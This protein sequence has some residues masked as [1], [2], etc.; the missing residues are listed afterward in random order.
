MTIA[1]KLDTTGKNEKMENANDNSEPSLGPLRVKV[2]IRGAFGVGKSAICER[3]WNDKFI[4]WPKPSIGLEIAK[5]K[6]ENSKGVTLDMTFFGICVEKNLL[7]RIQT[8]GK[9]ILFFCNE[10]VVQ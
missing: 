10:I 3:I 5:K 6:T 7:F 8:V 2:L 4:D 9:G 1:L